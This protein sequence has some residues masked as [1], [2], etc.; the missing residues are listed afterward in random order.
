MQIYV[1]GS[2][3]SYAEIM[4]TVYG[5]RNEKTGAGIDTAGDKS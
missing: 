5:K 4:E 1:K 3:S 2:G